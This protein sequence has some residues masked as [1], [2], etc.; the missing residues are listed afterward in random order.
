MLTITTQGSNSHKRHRHVCE[1]SDRDATFKTLA[2]RYKALL[3]GSRKKNSRKRHRHVCEH[4]DR[5]DDKDDDDNTIIPE[6][7]LILLASTMEQVW[8]LVVI[9]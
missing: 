4:S 7:E 5:D 6:D 2:E 9:K 3:A 8:I 1:H